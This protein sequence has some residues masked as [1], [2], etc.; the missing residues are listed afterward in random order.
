MRRARGSPCARPG[1]QRRRV[2]GRPARARRARRATAVVDEPADADL[3]RAPTSSHRVA[4]G[5]R[6]AGRAARGAGAALHGRRRRTARRR[7]RRDVPGRGA[8]AGV[9]DVDRRSSWPSCWPTRAPGCCAC[10]PSSPRR[11]PAAVELRPEI[12]TVVLDGPRPEFRRAEASPCI[13]GTTWPAS[14]CRETPYPTWA[15]SPALWLYT[16]GTTGQPKARHAPAREHSRTS[17]STTA[18]AC[19]ASAPRTVASR[20]RS[21]SSPTGWATPASSR[22]RPARRRVLERARPTPA[23]DRRARCA[24]TSADAVLRRCPT[25]YAAL[26][27]S[28][29]PDDTFAGVRQ[30]VSAGEALPAVLFD[31]FRPRFGVEVLDGIGSTEALHIFLSNRPGAGRPRHH[32][33]AGAR[34]RGASSAT[35]TA[36]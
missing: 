24:T 26:L 18:A 34:L 36:R 35:T 31:R 6:G 5:L 19:S 2:S 32:R 8:G 33:R 10:R 1:V 27:A 3:R 20:W 30:G 17:A 7:P 28:D 22:W 23:G 16:S 29:L 15:D 12:D 14:A 21:C 4:A 9:H 11:V 25:F 13:R